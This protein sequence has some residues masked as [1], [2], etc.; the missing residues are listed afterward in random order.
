MVKVRS[1]LLSKSTSLL[2]VLV[3]IVVAAG[4]YYLFR[5][6]FKMRE[7]NTCNTADCVTCGLTPREDDPDCNTACANCNLSA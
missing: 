2:Y 1:K 3:F 6:N 4:L 7:G 5:N